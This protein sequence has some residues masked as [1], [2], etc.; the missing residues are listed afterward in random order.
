MGLFGRLPHVEILVPEPN[1]PIA[2][3]TF[4]FMS[5]GPVKAGRYTVTLSVKDPN[6]KELLERAPSVSSEAVPAPLN[7]VITCMPFPL[8]GAGLYKV[9]A[10]VNGIED[11]SAHLKVGRQIIQ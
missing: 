1:I 6:Q 7:S 8:N 5:N 4:L 11:F 10:I 2:R 3:L 9:T